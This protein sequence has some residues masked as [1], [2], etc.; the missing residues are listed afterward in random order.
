MRSFTV[1][2]GFTLIETVIVITL[3]AAALTVA[4]MYVSSL[5][6]TQ[7][8]EQLIEKMATE[9][10]QIQRAMTEHMTGTVLSA[11]PN[12][13]RTEVTVAQLITANRLPAGFANRDGAVGTSPFGQPYRVYVFRITGTLAAGEN[14]LTWVVTESG[15]PLASR[16]ARIGAEDTDDAV[17]G[18]KQTVAGA[19]SKTHRLISGV[20]RPTTTTVS[21]DFN[22]FTKDI[23]YL[24]PAA[25]TAA[26]RSWVAILHGFA[27]L[28][29]GT[30]PTSPVGFVGDC[31]VL[32]ASR[33]CRIGGFPGNCTHPSATWTKPQCSFFGAGWEEVDQITV[34][35]PLG[36]AS[37]RSTPIGPLSYATSTDARTFYGG[38]EAPPPTCNIG[39]SGS[40]PC[41]GLDSMNLGG[42]YWNAVTTFQ[43]IRLND[44]PVARP[45]C[46]TDTAYNAYTGW[47]GV[48]CG[49]GRAT[50]PWANGTVIGAN[51]KHV[52]CCK[53]E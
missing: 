4:L 43:D 39:C 11:V 49:Y 37:V 19:L 53:P 36:Q 51:P 35:P 10:A 52:L 33:G 38:G 30:V 23:A 44:T 41:N 32:E 13:T 47:A 26:N 21:G 6:R 34:C 50:I 15:T 12:R 8:R 40:H 2:R 24:L 28:S 25:P 9:M 42:I 14:A 20:V 16:L 48:T 31:A 1:R 45:A 3:A 18:I 27:D 29:T 7:Q 22:G 5:S 46:S 17:L